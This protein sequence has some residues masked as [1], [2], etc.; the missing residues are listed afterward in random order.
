MKTL[1]LFEIKDDKLYTLFHS[2]GGRSRYVPRGIWLTSKK[3]KVRDGGSGNWYES[4][5]HV[6]TPSF[7]PE[8][9]LNKF[10]K[11]RTLAIVEVEVKN[12]R[13]K[14]TNPNILLAR[15]MKVPTGNSCVKEIIKIGEVA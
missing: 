3:Q 1:R 8:R 5:F 7:N 4:G 13:Q 14:P 10:R 11:P 12:V 6:F 15:C 9:F 2:I